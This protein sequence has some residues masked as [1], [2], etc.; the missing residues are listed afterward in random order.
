MSITGVINLAPRRIDTQDN[1]DPPRCRRSNTTMRK[2]VESAKNLAKF[3]RDQALDIMTSHLVPIHV[4][5]RVMAGRSTR[6][7]WSGK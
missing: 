3:D 7:N 4:A 1:I 2:I 6:M 5:I